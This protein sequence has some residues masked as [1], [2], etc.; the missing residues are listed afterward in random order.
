MHLSDILS[1]ETILVNIEGASKKRV[2]ELISDFCA[3][4]NEDIDPLEAFECLIARERLGATGIGCGVAIPHGRLPGLKMAVGVLVQL[5]HP[6]DFGASDKLP[7]DLIVGIF[8][9]EKST[10]EHLAL[11][12]DLAKIFCDANLRDKMRK[13]QDSATLYELITKAG[14]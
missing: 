3:Q 1:P 12:S 4:E 2:L 10:D 11:L 7:V 8:V 6:I 14:S 9:P 13:A 5:E